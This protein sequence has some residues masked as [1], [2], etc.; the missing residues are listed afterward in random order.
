M[1]IARGM[2][3]IGQFKFPKWRNI[4]ESPKWHEFYFEKW[5]EFKV[6]RMVRIPSNIKVPMSLLFGKIHFPINLFMKCLFLSNCQRICRMWMLT[7]PYLK[8]D[9]TKSLSKLYFLTT[10][11][12]EES[13]K[14]SLVV[15][16]LWLSVDIYSANSALRDSSMNS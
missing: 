2:N 5:L 16:L 4:M 8:V 11:L 6:G 10:S 7:T 3:L 9:L 12:F 13:V 15:L 14:A 1:E